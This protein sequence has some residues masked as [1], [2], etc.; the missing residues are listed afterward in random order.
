MKIYSATSNSTPDY[1]NGIQNA[2]AGATPI[3][4]PSGLTVGWNQP[5]ASKSKSNSASNPVL[6]AAGVWVDPSTGQP[7]HGTFSSGSGQKYYS[8]GSEVNSI[9]D[10]GNEKPN[11]DVTSTSKN[12]AITG[13]VNG[14]V[15][16]N[17]NA[18]SALGKSFT[19]YLAEATRVGAQSKDQL[20]KDQAALDTTGTENR[21]NS[22]VSNQAQSLDSNNKSYETNQRS[23]LGDVAGQNK[24]YAG[25]VADRLAKLRSDLET[26]NS[27]Y[28]KNA[29]AVAD[30]AYQKAV[31]QNSLYHL[32]TSTPTSG[33]G[34]MDSRMIRAYNDVN[35]P[36]QAELA[37][38]RYAQTGTLNDLQA[39][40]DNQ[41]YNNQMTQFA[42]ASSLNTDLANRYGSTTQLNTA[43]DVNAAQ[44][45]QG[46]KA[47]TA[48]MSR[49]Q[50]ANYLS[51]LAIPLQ[52][53]Q[54]VLSGQIANTG[55]LSALDQS[56][57]YI[58]VSQPYTGADVPVT[59]SFGQ[60]APSG[61]GGGNYGRS[62]ASFSNPLDSIGQND[63]GAVQQQWMNTPEGVAWAK[64]NRQPTSPYA[65]ATSYTGTP[66]S[67]TGYVDSGGKRYFSDG[68]VGGDYG[69]QN[70]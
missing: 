26:Q 52:I 3:K 51:Q 23:V 53:S 10:V 37:N 20:A 6:S 14:L 47:Q 8:N 57:N 16:Q 12:P 70:Q 65:Y 39:Q 17:A 60:S 69:Y 33:S 29:Q 54:Q 32:G 58:T 61:G 36:L 15:G 31:R 22:A 50:A 41:L 28:E 63:L 40:A 49:A 45:I 2:F 7:A 44:Y 46:L 34:A 11:F 5:N 27:L 4:D 21:I 35:I 9:A 68:S 1:L 38:R 19:D 62:G 24:N 30:Q 25:T 59:P 13:Q 48:G 55:A 67:G 43:A 18:N 42:G 64:A 66:G 56:A